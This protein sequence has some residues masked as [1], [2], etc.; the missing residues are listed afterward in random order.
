MILF[1]TDVASMAINSSDLCVGVSLG[2][3]KT[4]WKMIQISGRLARRPEDN[5]VF[6]TVVP[7]RHT[8]R[9]SALERDEA[10]CMKSLFNSAACINRS[11]YDSFKI[12]DA[13][14]IYE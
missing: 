5:A 12:A 8:V 14:V 7:K 4:R 11:L 2:V 9:A 13:T 3:P 6:I 1:S 10:K